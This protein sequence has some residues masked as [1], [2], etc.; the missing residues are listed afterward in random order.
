MIPLARGHRRRTS[1]FPP[2]LE[3]LV[4]VFFLLVAWNG[5]VIAAQ[6][7]PPEEQAAAHLEAGNQRLEAGDF[8]GAVTEY[9]AGMALYPRTSLLFNIGVAELRQEHLI[10]AAEAFEATLGRPETTDEVAGQAREQLARIHEKLALVSVSGGNGARLLVD[11]Q[12]RGTLPLKQSLRVL[13]GLHSVRATKDGHRPFET[14]IS[15]AAGAH[16]DVRVAG[17]E[18]LAAPPA[19]RPRYWLWATLG[20]VVVAGVVIGIVATRG[21]SSCPSGVDCIDIKR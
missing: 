2:S 16:V 21:G 19:H 8:A 5:I 7:P 3:R 12:P 1:P 15:G 13:P 17:L 11:G 14:T 10:E 18:P 9:R 6:L 20:A 4:A